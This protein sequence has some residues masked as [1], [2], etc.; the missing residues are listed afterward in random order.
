MSASRLQFELPKNSKPV[1]YLDELIAEK[2][3]IRDCDLEFGRLFLDTFDWRLFGNG[4]M[5]MTDSLEGRFKTIWQPCDKAQVLGVLFSDRIPVFIGDLPAGKMRRILAPILEMRALLPQSKL[6]CL[7]QRLRLQNKHDKTVLRLNIESYTIKDAD[8]E[9]KK[10][11]SRVCLEAVRGYDKA[12]SEVAGLF[13]ELLDLRPLSENLL[14][15]ALKRVGRRP[16][17]YTSKLDLKLEPSMRIDSAVRII[18]RRLFSTLENNEPGTKQNIDSEFLHD[19]RVAIRRT[20]ALLDQSKEFLPDD[21]VENFACEFAWLAKATGATRD[22]DVYLLNFEAYRKTIPVSIR[23]DLEP[24]HAFLQ[25]KQKNAQSELVKVLESDRYHR[26]KKQWKTFL[27]EAIEEKPREI[28]ADTRVKQIADDSIRR[29]YKSIR[30]K[31]RAID[32]DAPPARLHRLRIHCKKLRYLIEFFESLY[33][34]KQIRHSIKALKGLQDNLGN[35]QDLAVQEKNL[36]Q[37]ST[38]MM[39]S[40]SAARTLLAMGI[41]VQELEKQRET[42]R[43]EFMQRFEEFDSAENR[44][45]FHSLFQNGEGDSTT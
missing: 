18:F 29:V 14:V 2:G 5:L 33:S 43:R 8:R 23:K 16:L 35:F 11:R 10:L 12:F 41:L 9:E 1:D 38:E 30:R 19:Y 13:K 36:R 27:D 31:G 34:G 25:A 28:L 20:R 21:V 42:V 6:E 24:L 26:L 32:P 45:L 17:E 39:E 3:F 7:Q 44:T 40:R 15:A 4:F 22:L 37:Y